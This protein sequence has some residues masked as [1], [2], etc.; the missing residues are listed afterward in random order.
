MVVIKTCEHCGV[1][2]KP[3]RRFCSPRCAA[4]GTA[5]LRGNKLRGRGDGKAYRKREGVHEHRLVA[6]RKLGRKLNP[7]EVVHH[8]N[9]DILDNRPE[10]LEVIES[11]SE[12][13]RMHRPGMRSRRIS[14]RIR[15]MILNEHSKGELSQ[16]EIGRKFDVAQTTV[17]RMV[18]WIW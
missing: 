14:E 10:N 6:E 13:L 16:D 9:G 17:S 11:Q 7:G 1:E 5:V 15:L 18:R 4:R 8:M 3:N 2:I 12:H